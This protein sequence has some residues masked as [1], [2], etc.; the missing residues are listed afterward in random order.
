MTTNVINNSLPTKCSQKTFFIDP[1]FE[2]NIVRL[3][4]PHKKWRI[5]RESTMM[6]GKKA[7]NIFQRH[8]VKQNLKE[9]F[10]TNRIEFFQ[11]QFIEKVCFF[12]CVF[13]RSVWVWLIFCSVL[14][15]VCYVAKTVCE[16]IT[17]TMWI[18]FLCVHE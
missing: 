14:C 15:P 16:L 18:K 6:N 11:V 12:F 17:G 7:I 2:T 3:H 8:S 5:T 13:E 4:R 1:L 9:N 10:G